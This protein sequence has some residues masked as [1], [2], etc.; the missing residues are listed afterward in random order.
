MARASQGAG[1]G[2]KVIRYQPR[3]APTP[4]AIDRAAGRLFAVGLPGV[5]RRMRDLA[6]AQRRGCKIPWRS[7]PVRPPCA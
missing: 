3:V 7:F 5:S 6:E 4:E 1:Q 2:R